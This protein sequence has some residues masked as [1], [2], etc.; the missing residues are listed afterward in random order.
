MIHTI[1]A[2]VK[3]VKTAQPHYSLGTSNMGGSCSKQLEECKTKVKSLEEKIKLYESGI[4]AH[5]MKSSQTNLGL[6]NFGVENSNNGDCECS[7]S[8]W[9]IL[10]IL[11]T[12][13]MCIIVMY[14]GYHCLVAYC[15]RRDRAKEL[16]RRNFMDMVEQRL[17]AP[18]DHQIIQLTPQECSQDHLHV[19]ERY[20]PPQ[21]PQPTFE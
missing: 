17:K 3:R 6:V 20:N 19:P 1:T 8:I 13:V 7:S 18:S 21:A 2:R 12:I 10:E 9:G 16:K 4:T 14:I 11:A 15:N 5:E